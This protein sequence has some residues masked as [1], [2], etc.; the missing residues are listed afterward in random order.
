MAKSKG[1]CKN[2]I[3]PVKKSKGSG[4]KAAISMKKAK[5]RGKSYSDIDIALIR[6]AYERNKWN[7]RQIANHYAAKHWAPLAAKKIL[8]KIKSGLDT[9]RK[10]GSGRPRSAR[11]MANAK[12]ADVALKKGGRKSA[13]ASCRKIAADLK[14][15][16]STVHRIS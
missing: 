2:A 14:L 15:R 12:K 10:V 7:S 13:A 6:D 4:E 9:K 3:S 11:T 8:R 1:R 16:R 5:G